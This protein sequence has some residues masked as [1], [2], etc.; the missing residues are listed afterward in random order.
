M[1]L[2]PECKDNYKLRR[3]A[4]TQ[5]EM[6]RLD[7][8][9]MMR[10]FG[11]DIAVNVIRHQKNKQT[12]GH[13][14]D[15]RGKIVK[16]SEPMIRIR[17]Y[18]NVNRRIPPRRVRML[19]RR[20]VNKYPTQSVQQNKNKGSRK[21][22]TNEGGRNQ[23][24]NIA[25]SLPN[26]QHKILNDDSVYS[27]IHSTNPINR[28]Q[29]SKQ[30]LEQ[31]QSKINRIDDSSIHLQHQENRIHRFDDSLLQTPQNAI[32]S[33]LQS[34]PTHTNIIN[35]MKSI[36]KDTKQRVTS[37]Q[38]SFSSHTPVTVSTEKYE[39]NTPNK[40][41][42]TEQLDTLH[43]GDLNDWLHNKIFNEDK[44][45]NR[46][47]SRDDITEVFK[48]QP[49][50]RVLKDQPRIRIPRPRDFKQPRIRIKTLKKGSKTR[51]FTP[52]FHIPAPRFTDKEQPITL[53][54]AF[55]KRAGAVERIHSNVQVLCLR[56]CSDA[57]V[58][59]DCSCP[60]LRHF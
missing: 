2:R 41:K 36:I 46:T 34:R 56:G 27:F 60:S 15:F 23:K 50:V 8:G 49:R 24:I 1:Q 26:N 38:T 28:I 47:V 54:D 6:G 25:P 22:N 42:A 12:S 14:F 32:N 37:T 43:N 10:H 58:D 7:E 18:K 53:N 48:E 35:G 19:R 13:R 33:K 5:D 55:Q 57:V 30:Q 31:P 40:L 11:G 44:A 39:K 45:F 59:C 16:D 3:K 51:V 20:L 21:Q 17:K 4:K 29:D 9:E 52:N